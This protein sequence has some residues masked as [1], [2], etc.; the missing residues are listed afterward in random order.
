[1]VEVA[2]AALEGAV[3]IGGMTR[4]P[5]LFAVDRVVVDVLDDEAAAD[6][7]E[8]IADGRRAAHSAGAADQRR[9]GFGLRIE[10]LDRFLDL[11]GARNA[12][13]GL[14]DLRDRRVE[15]DLFDEGFVVLRV[16]VCG[17]GRDGAAT[18]SDEGGGCKNCIQPCPDAPRL[19]H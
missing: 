18:G 6:A 3:E 8:Q 9:T 4:E 13:V 16:G 17:N 10:R 5:A 2:L 12:D 19:D 7:L 11:L 14:I 15:L 1:M